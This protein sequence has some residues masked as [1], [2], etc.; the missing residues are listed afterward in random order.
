M[1]GLF[2]IGPAFA[3]HFGL[4]GTLRLVQK[5]KNPAQG[6]VRES[7]GLAARPE[8]SVVDYFDFFTAATAAAPLFRALSKAVS[9]VAAAAFR[10]LLTWARLSGA[11]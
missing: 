4:P 8:S 9:M 3:R 10:V 11:G 5:A 6:W 1:G 7:A 2:S